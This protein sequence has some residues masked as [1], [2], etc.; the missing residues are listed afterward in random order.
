MSFFRKKFVGPFPLV[1]E[2]VLKEPKF[3]SEGYLTMVSLLN[4]D[5][6]GREGGMKEYLEVN[7]SNQESLSC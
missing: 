4:T 2:D 6:I 3:F 5:K 7:S 1:C